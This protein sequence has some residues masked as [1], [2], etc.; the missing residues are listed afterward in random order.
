MLSNIL[1][2]KSIKLFEKSKFYLDTLEAIEY[3]KATEA[4]IKGWLNFVAIK[5][6]LTVRI[7]IDLNYINL[8]PSNVGLFGWKLEEPLIIVLDI[9]EVKLLNTL[10]NELAQMDFNSMWN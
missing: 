2:Y 8:H 1:N 6:F 7:E 10:E 5:E 9:S 3:L 4:S